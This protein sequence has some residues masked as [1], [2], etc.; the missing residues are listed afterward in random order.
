MSVR[1]NTSDP[2]KLLAYFKKLIDEK[3][4]VTWSYDGD[5]DFTHAK[6]EW[7][8][9]AWLRPH[10]KSGYLLFTIIPPEEITID[11]AVYGVYHGRFIESFLTHCDT[12]FSTAVASALPTD[13]DVI[14]NKKKG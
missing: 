11:D 3:H 1:F 13:G 10:I 14:S 12:I 6:T 7:K 5:G 8:N 9:K 2:K 4:V